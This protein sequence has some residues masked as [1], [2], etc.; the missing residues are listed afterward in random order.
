MVEVKL[1]EFG[2]KLL[3]NIVV[4]TSDNASVMIKF[5]RLSNVHHQLWGNHGMH[6]TIIDAIYNS[7]NPVQQEDASE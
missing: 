2:L 7:S 6:I 4:L 3:C 5:S 1:S